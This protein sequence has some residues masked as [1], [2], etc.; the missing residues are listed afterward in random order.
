MKKLLITFAI[1]LLSMGAFAQTGP[2]IT[3]IVP[4]E[5]VAA[6]KALKPSAAGTWVYVQGYYT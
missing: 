5:N 3:Q 2:S 1:L 4:I 6:L